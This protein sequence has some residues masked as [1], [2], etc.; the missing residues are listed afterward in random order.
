[1]GIRHHWPVDPRG[2]HFE[3]LGIHWKCLRLYFDFNADPDTVFHSTEGP[4][5]YLASKIN[6]DPDPLP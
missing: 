2:F 6:A 4:D 5:P 3:L 1:M